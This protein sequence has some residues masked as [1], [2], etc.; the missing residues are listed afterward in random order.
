M[1]LGLYQ[2]QTLKLNMTTELRQAI[3]VLQYSVTELIEFIQEQAEENPII[4]MKDQ[5][6]WPELGHTFAHKKSNNSNHTQDLQPID[7]HYETESYVEQLLKEVQCMRMSD[8]KRKIVRYLILNL[9]ENGYLDLDEQEAITVLK[10]SI[11]QLESG[12]MTLQSLE[13]VGIG[14]RSLK[15]CLELQL[16][17]SPYFENKLTYILL[18]N[19]HFVA[20]RKWSELEKI[21]QATIKELKLAL[22]V[23]QTL[24]PKPLS[25]Y[26]QTQSQ[27]VYPDI[28]INKTPLGFDFLIDYDLPEFTYNAQYLN[29]SKTDD[30]VQKYI[31]KKYQQYIWLRKCLEQRRRTIESFVT[32]VLKRQEDFFKY[33]KTSLKPMTMKEVAS[34]VGVHESTISRVVKNKFMQ[35][36]V[37]VYPLKDL[38]TSKIKTGTGESESSEVVKKQIQDLIAQE[39]KAK[40]LSD[41]LIAKLLESEYQLILSRRTVA[42]YREQL[43]ILSSI[44]RKI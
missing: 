37:G 10:C 28:I 34:E 27:Y 31:H 39:D 4:E 43:N 9:D 40:P 19:L 14:A 25:G 18:D 5:G 41:Q 1:E 11:E 36:P 12:I 33:G 32:V 35:T 8:V 22:E 3:T 26:A 2:Q 42:K 20:K 17:A 13:P 44:L 23:V 29:L 7:Y 24:N 16:R 21:S 30:R 6:N 38:F 15:E